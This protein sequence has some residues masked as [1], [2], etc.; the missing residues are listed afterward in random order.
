[1]GIA[2]EGT[3][4]RRLAARR[5]SVRHFDLSR[6]VP[7]ELLKEILE[8]ARLA[9][10]AENAQPWRFIVIDEPDIR[11][12]LVQECFKGIYAFTRRVQAPVYLALCGVRGLTDRGGRLLTSVSYTY[13]DCGIAG[14]HAVLAATEL[15]LGTCWIGLF[16]RRRAR[17]LL[18]VPRGVELVALIALGWPADPT[19][20]PP[21]TRGRKPL[22]AIAW[23]GSWGGRP[24]G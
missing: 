16:D 22:A 12:R 14:E 21:A 10:S 8:A 23:H 7:E 6:P 5:A 11:T 2:E 15:G 17:K 9:P 20:K 4:L 18:G 24:L 19:R 3:W 13:I 1:M